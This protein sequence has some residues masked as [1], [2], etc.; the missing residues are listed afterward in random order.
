MALS[1]IREKNQEAR[2]E[3]A[4]GGQAATVA[5]LPA[6]STGLNPRAQ[7]G[8]K[9]PGNFR[10]PQNVRACAHFSGCGLRSHHVFQRSRWVSLMLPPPT[11]RPSRGAEIA[12]GRARLSWV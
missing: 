9:H 12:V 11:W 6:S 10:G 7:G 3:E 8:G 5:V 4:G 1:R 2:R